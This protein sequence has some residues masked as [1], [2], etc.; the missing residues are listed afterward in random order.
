M[1]T[2]DGA[3]DA[4]TLTTPAS[5][6]QPVA[7]LADTPMVPE[8][9]AEYTATIVPGDQ[10]TLMPEFA[11]AI[12]TLQSTM[13]RPVWILVHG[14]RGP[15]WEIDESMRAG[16]FGEREHLRSCSDGA[17]LVIDSPGGLARSAYQIATLFRRHCGGFAVVVP[18]MAKSAATLLTL[19]ADQIYLGRDAELG[20]LDAQIWDSDREEYSSALDEVQALERLN[21]VALDFVDQAM[22]LLINRT[23]KKVDALLPPVLHFAAELMQPLLTKIDTVHYTGWSRVLKVAEDY[24][25]RLLTPNYSEA[26]AKMIAREL[27]NSY[28]EHEFVIDRE[29]LGGMLEKTLA[30]ADKPTQTVIDGLERILTDH[31]LTALGRIER[32]GNTDDGRNGHA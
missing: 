23:G 31:T 32:R 22:F 19:G 24:A 4:A 25:T 15:H 7:S 17:I 2:A 30:E 11:E 1:S 28:S 12:L 26:E 13:G 10:G 9:P 18:R 5:P 20:P 27:V 21:S 8:A 14:S 29:E 16:F 3:K 6:D